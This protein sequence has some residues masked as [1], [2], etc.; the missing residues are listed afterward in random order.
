[1]SVIVPEAPPPEPD[2]IDDVPH[3]RHTGQLLGHA[4][5][6]AEFLSAF[7]SGRLHHAWLITGPAG[8]GKATLAWRLARFLLATPPA[9]GLFDAPPPDTLDID[10]E[11]PVA[12]RIVALSE[13]G[14]FLLRRP[15]DASKKKLSTQITIDETRKLKGFFQMSASDGGRRVVIVDAADDMNQSAANALLKVLEEPPKG[16]VLLLI[17]HQP[18]RLLPTIRSRCRRLA[19]APLGPADHAAA[20][21]ATGTETED[22]A[23]LHGLSEGSVGDAVRLAQAGGPALYADLVAL[24]GTMPAFDRPAAMKLAEATRDEARFE[25][26]L[27]LTDRLLG[28]IARTGA[29][30]SAPPGIVPGEEEVLSR[31]APDADAGRAWAQLADGLTAR[32]RRGRAVNLD[33]PALILDMFLAIGRAA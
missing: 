8:I 33:P 4:E 2:R 3:P 12:R 21:A 23:A 11:H 24:F 10:P 19:L 14:L 30:G 26:I 32:A 9:G 6:E 27:T 22:A 29:T 13:P 25:L 5:A 7:Q 16:A 28:R 15:W 18:A 20:L 17:A 1:M 31:L